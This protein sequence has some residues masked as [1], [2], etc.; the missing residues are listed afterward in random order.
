MNAALEICPKLSENCCARLCAAAGAAARAV[1][2]RP[3]EASK[4]VATA[5]R[6]V[7]RSV[8]SMLCIGA[9]DHGTGM[10]REVVRNQNSLGGG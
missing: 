4:C 3:S 5:Q 9:H 10:G 2:P 6:S 1:A 8:S 7:R